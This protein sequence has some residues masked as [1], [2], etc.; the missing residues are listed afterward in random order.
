MKKLKLILIDI[1]NTLIDIHTA[2]ADALD[3]VSNKYF[4]CNYSDYLG[5]IDLTRRCRPQDLTAEH[6]ALHLYMGSKSSSR[7]VSVE[8]LFEAYEDYRQEVVQKIKPMPGA[9][10]FLEKVTHKNIKVVALTNNYLS[11]VIERLAR[12]NLGKYLH[13]VI[14]PELY[15]IAKPSSFLFQTVL[16]EENTLP[17][18]AIMI[19]DNEVTDGGCQSIG[20][21]FEHI[22]RLNS[23]DKY[24]EIYERYIRS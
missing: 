5:F 20:V 8:E 19:G 1:D 15:G 16:K 6:P 18:E 23:A 3:K 24:N 17:S 2:H 7:P 13:N 21:T 11:L 10:V 22:T 9:M 12:L 4:N 14:T